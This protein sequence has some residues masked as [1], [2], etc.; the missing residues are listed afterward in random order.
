[1]KGM[2]KLLDSVDEMRPKKVERTK[3]VEIT[4][5]YN[6]IPLLF[7]DLHTPEAYYDQYGRRIGTLRHL[8][9]MDVRIKREIERG[10]QEKKVYKKIKKELL[11]TAF[12]K[13]IARN[14][15]IVSFSG[16]KK[17]DPINGFISSV[18]TVD[19]VN[20]G[21]WT[22]NVIA[23]AVFETVALV[24]GGIGAY[25]STQAIFDNAKYYS[26]VEYLESIDMGSAATSTQEAGH[27]AFQEAI[28]K[29]ALSYA[30]LG[31]GILGLKMVAKGIKWA[32]SPDRRLAKR[33]EKVSVGDMV[34]A[35]TKE[36]FEYFVNYTRE[37]AD[38]DP[39]FAR[40]CM[41]KDRAIL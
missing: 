34:T 5:Y 26:A 22:W 37:K 3:D 36:D 20:Y 33:A 40:Q 9:C 13:P 19:R 12:E 11:K 35:T 6:I 31:A 38:T 39:V 10:K 7:P 2:V 1:M 8:E 25:H 21:G 30:L 28:P 4:T 18:D 29:A 27:Q 23:P 14:G 32:L 17:G 15:T 41:D 24:G 16:K